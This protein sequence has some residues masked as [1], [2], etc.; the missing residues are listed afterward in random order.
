MPEIFPDPGNVGNAMTSPGSTDGPTLGVQMLGKTADGTP[1]YK[2][3]PLAAGGGSMAV[4]GTVAAIQS[5]SWSVTVSNASLAVTGT[6][7]QTTQPVSIATLPALTA[8]SAA[9]GSVTVT[10]S[11]AVTGTF[12]QAIQPVSGTVVVSSSTSAYQAA[13]IAGTAFVGASGVQSLS[14]TGSVRFLFANPSG[15]GK[16]AYIDAVVIEQT[17]AALAFVTVFTNPTTAP[18]STSGVLLSNQKIGGGSP[19][20]TIAADNSATEISG[21]TTYSTMAA[22]AGSRTVYNNA[23]IVV[24][25]NNTVGINIPFT[26][27]VS[28]NVLVYWREV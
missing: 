1:A 24:P 12:W 23:L 25:A 3:L 8:G 21:G 27:A 16:T 10:G 6:F 19:V 28:V 11:V 5:G 20:C 9:I 17:S 26:V 2:P 13:A 22:N 15:S 4:S 18:S 7:W 14:L